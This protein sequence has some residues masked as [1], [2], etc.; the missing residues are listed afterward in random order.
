MLELTMHGQ[1]LFFIIQH[2]EISCGMWVLLWFILIFHF[3]LLSGG[4]VLFL[5][6]VIFFLYYLLQL[7]VDRSDAEIEERFFQHL[8]AAASIGRAHY[9]SRREGRFRPGSH[10]HPQ[11]LVFSPNSNTSGV[12]DPATASRGADNEPVHSII[13]S[14]PL[15]SATTPERELASVTNVSPGQATQIASSTSGASSTSIRPSISTTGYLVELL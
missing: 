3:L 4:K 1:L 9:I 2:L 7:A 11:Y 14:E 5:Y 12:S 13:A 10:D 15:V 8:A 6:K